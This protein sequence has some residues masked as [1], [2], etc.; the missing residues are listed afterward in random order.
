MDTGRG[1]RQELGSHEHRQ[2]SNP[3]KTMIWAWD[4]LVDRSLRL[5]AVYTSAICRMEGISDDLSL[6]R[7]TSYELASAGS[8]VYWAR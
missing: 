6:G 3:G 8:Q 5:A 1:P 7:M 2:G 4:V